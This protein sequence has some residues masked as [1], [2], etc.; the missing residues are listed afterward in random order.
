[1][2]S[3]RGGTDPRGNWS[4]GRPGLI[5]VGLRFLIIRVNRKDKRPANITFPS[6]HR[7]VG[8]AVTSSLPAISIS[9][10]LTPATKACVLDYFARVIP[11]GEFPN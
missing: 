4:F 9:Y 11:T 1:M 10:S 5:Y 6:G 8:V 3:V 7:R 2:I